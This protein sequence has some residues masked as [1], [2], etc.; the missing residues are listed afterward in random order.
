MIMHSLLYLNNA[1]AGC[2]TGAKAQLRLS[3]SLQL[4]AWHGVWGVCGGSRVWAAENP[5]V[6]SLENNFMP[7]SRGLHLPSSQHKHPCYLAPAGRN[8]PKAQI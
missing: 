7:C 5:S 1:L 4:E 2:V 6:E 3:L 8:Q